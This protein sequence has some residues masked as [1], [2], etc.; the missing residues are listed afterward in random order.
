MYDCIIIGG[1]LLGMLSALEL[2]KTGRRVCLLERQA[3]A[4][5]ST[6][7]GGGI[8]SPLYPWRYRAPVTALAQWSQAHYPALCESLIEH[9]AGD[10]EYR[11][12]GLL[13]FDQ[14]EHAAQAWAQANQADVQILTD[15]KAVRG[16]EQA[17][18]NLPARALWLPQVAQIRNPRLGR[19]LR[20]YLDLHPV[21]TVKEHTRAEEILFNNARVIGVRSSAGTFLAPEIVIA[22]G[23]WSADFL[24]LLRTPA[25][26]PV[27]GQMIVFKAAP[28]LLK[29][30]VL[31]DRRYLIPRCDGHILAGS[32]LE[33]VGFDK[34]A[35]P[36]G[37]AALQNFAQE[38]L[39]ALASCAV[40]K[41]WAGLRP[42]SPDGVPYI[43]AHPEYPGLYFNSGHFR[44]GVVL[45]LASAR[46][47]A[48]VISGAP[49]IVDARPYAL[50]A[51]READHSPDFC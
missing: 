19:A 49:P 39:P 24:G 40:V 47:L 6:W 14:E 9:G 15:E 43:G 36:Q 34:S 21:I 7:A 1:G 30:I 37:L 8:I 45:G 25:I 2:A 38:L 28:G 16:N 18:A 11:R 10:P 50:D 35:T 13:I 51:P 12:S 48:D 23:A 26:T 22:A 17:L 4:Q 46:L 32:T 31:H 29:R 33:H 42:G 41:H 20:A 3:C 5:E 44:N 27:R